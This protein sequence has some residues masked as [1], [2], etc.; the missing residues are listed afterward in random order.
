MESVIC[1]HCEEAHI[2]P[3]QK[4]RGSFW[5]DIY[6][7]SCGRRSA[8]N[9]IGMAL[10]YFIITWD[11]AFFGFMSIYESDFRYFIAMLAGW[12]LL[13]TFTY[14]LPLVRLRNKVVDPK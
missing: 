1:P 7:P 14:Y 11:L 3:K 5:M 6:C 8:L 2:T 13:Q 4:I 9:P 12:L 10:M